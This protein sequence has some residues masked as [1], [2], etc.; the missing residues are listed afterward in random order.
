MW[1]ALKDLLRKYDRYMRHINTATTIFLHSV[2]IF[3]FF[4]LYFLYVIRNVTHRNMNIFFCGRLRI[5][6]KIC[7]QLIF[8]FLAQPCFN[9]MKRNARYNKRRKK[10]SKQ[11]YNSNNP[12]GYQKQQQNNVFA[13]KAH[14]SLIFAIYYFISLRKCVCV[15]GKPRATATTVTKSRMAQ[16]HMTRSDPQPVWG[17][18]RLLWS[19]FFSLTIYLFHFSSLPAQV[20]F[21][22]ARSATVPPNRCFT[23][24]YRCIHKYDRKKKTFLQCNTR[25]KYLKTI[26]INRTWASSILQAFPETNT[27]GI[28]CSTFFLV[29]TNQNDQCGRTFIFRPLNL[30][31]CSPP[32]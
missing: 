15:V 22:T 16:C 8:H 25:T 1:M 27:G 7:W 29:S 11:M 32:K 24:K 6:A 3:V 5:L 13:G 17:A 12:N 23:F 9:E 10:K 26:G 28:H 18:Y 21:V 14:F 31:C 2:F 30:S 20:L 4:Q 19:L